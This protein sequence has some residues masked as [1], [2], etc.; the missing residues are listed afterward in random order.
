M[1]LFDYSIF[2]TGD[3][4]SNS[5]GSISILPFGGT[6]PYTVEWINPNLG[7]DTITIVPSLRTGLGAG[8]YAVRL[9]DST[10]P[11][12]YEFFVNIPVSSGVCVNVVGVQNTTCGSNN[13]AITGTSTSNFSSSNFYL[14]SGT[15]Q[16]VTSAVT[17]SGSVVFTNLTAGTYNVA[18]LD[19]GGCTG[20]SETIV[21]EDSSPFDYG[22]YVVPNSSCGG[23]PLGKIY[24]TGQT[25]PSPYTYLWNNG[26][27]TSFV[28][29]LTEGN[30][31]VTVTNADG[32][33]LSKNIILSK[34]NP[35]GFGNFVVTQPSC[36]SNNGGVVM[37][38]T[39]GTA[40]FYYS[41]STGDFEISYSPNYTLTGLSAGQVS[42]K[43]TD[44]GFC[45]FTETVQLLTPNGMSSVSITGTNSS[46]S[47]TDGEI[48]VTVQGGSTPYTYTLVYPTGNTNVIS[49]TNSTQEFLNLTAGTYSVFVEDSSGCSYNDEITLITQNKFTIGTQITGSTCGLNN[50][51][52][53][54]FKTTGGTAPFDYILDSTSQIIDTTQS[55]VT[56]TNVSQGAHTI[57]VV[58][59][60]GCRQNINF[61]IDYSEPISYSLYSSSCG[62]GTQGSITTFISSGVP[63][64]TFY[65]SDNVPN[66][67]QQIT[68]TGL[69]A[70]TYSVTVVDSTG[71]SLRRTTDVVCSQSFISYQIY[72]MGQE[73]FQ[74]QS[75]TKC[76]LLQMLNEGFVDLTSLNEGC[77]LNS[78]VFAAKVSVDPTGLTYTNTFFTATTLNQAPSDNLWYS[79]LTSLLTSIP[80]IQS[81]TIDALSNKITIQTTVG[82]PL[83]NQIITVDVLIEYDIT[84]K[85]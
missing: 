85:Q 70:G 18:T 80:G 23:D 56:F 58:D 39:G 74:L 5:A 40:P 24:V 52:V 54:V 15:G 53:E 43:V 29:G 41:A 49:N 76:G 69:T 9:N 27:T 48:L 25:G 42:I 26:A 2:V 65:W 28:T 10:L 46:C 73:Q 59:A 64:F 78:A 13:G 57:S 19:L 14:Y 79:T 7:A 37:T 36:F 75:G 4:Q 81:V 32:C 77:V 6:P 51:I 16:F 60:D 84:C 72:G 20:F 38:I 33:V 68:V 55:A 62:T 63:P 34:V 11:I 3:C 47:N 21:V 61:F 67:P 22:L 82:G 17:N 66:N 8:A 12:N 44:S 83:N 45:T 30:Y 50:A 1:A 35:V 31:S 71:C